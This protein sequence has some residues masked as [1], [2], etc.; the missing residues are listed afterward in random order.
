MFLTSAYD[1][2]SRH[3]VAVMHSGH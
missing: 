1:M 2:I 3:E